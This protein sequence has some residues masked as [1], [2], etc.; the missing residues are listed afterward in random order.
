MVIGC[1]LS[2]ASYG[3]RVVYGVRVICLWLWVTGVLLRTLC[4]W[5]RGFECVLVIV[6]WLL[7]VGCCSPVY[8]CMTLNVGCWLRVTG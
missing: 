4:C 8:D 3:L 1:W 6:Y 5:V 7:G 2:V